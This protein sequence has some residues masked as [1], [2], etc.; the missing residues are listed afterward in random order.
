MH[1]ALQSRLPIVPI[2]LTGT[3]RAW[4]KNSLRVR[5]APLTVKYLPPIKTVDWEPEKIN[6]YVEMVHDLYVEN[7]PESQKPLVSE[8][9]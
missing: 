3:H 8:C 4:R 1:I 5:P 7:L 9:K 6:E 2:V